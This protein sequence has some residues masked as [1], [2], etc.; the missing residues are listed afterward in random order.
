MSY[1]SLFYYAMVIA[2]LIIY[3]V[4]PKRFRWLVLL[5]GS[6]Y[7]YARVID[8][9]KQAAVFLLSIA[10][11]Y[12]AGLL[13]QKLNS[14]N[15]TRSAAHAGARRAVLFVGIILSA[16]PLLL[17]KLGDFL[18]GSVMHKPGVSWIVPVGLSFYTLQLAAYLV[19]IYRGEIDAQL[20]PLKYGL[21][22]T[23]FPQVIQ[24][25]IPRYKQLHKELFEGNDYNLDNIM[26]GIQLV[27]WGFF[28]KFMIADKAAVIV[29][30]VFDNYHAYSGVYVWVAAIL[31]SIQLYAD[32]LSCT[33]MSQGVSEM[34]GIHLVNN[35]NHP[36]F[37][38]SIKE[39]WRRWHM[40]LSFW[41]RDYV[42]IPL[43]G[44]QR[45]KIFKWVNLIITFAV[46]GLW[47]G[48]SWKFVFWGLLHAFYQIAGEIRHEI[49]VK[50]RLGRSQMR[51]EKLEPDRSQMR[52]EKL[53]IALQR[54]GTF[55]L[56]MLA[57][58]IFRAESLRAALEMIRT[59]I[60]G[61][62]PWVLFDDSLFRL[63]L[64]WK[65]C[66]VLMISIGILFWISKLQESG[67]V[68][69]D[70]F[71]RQNTALRWTIYLVAIWTIWIFGSYG[72]GFD[73][74]SFIYGGF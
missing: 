74:Q 56:V 64:G 49:A 63:G 28:L 48:G 41:L 72:F 62:N 5:A 10:V 30:A 16:L 65:E 59:M 3:Y 33:T 45:G 27:I 39:F 8:S 52:S 44:N 69:R 66:V 55:I 54:L 12:A 24:G 38:T 11:S 32:F 31:Y 7:F 2:L 6:V 73:A 46:S 17:V 9:W 14:S 47:H 40:S 22:A 15:N 67:I 53:S 23:F 20:N 36:Y 19:D 42:Y 18:S 29:N 43:G 35:F 61:F 25:P 58:I 13:L 50:L 26:R 71:S 4:L 51:S 60:F 70:W 1:T 34:F 37:A 21:F 68:L 57:W